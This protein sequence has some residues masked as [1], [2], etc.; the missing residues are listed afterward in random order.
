MNF[1]GLNKWM[2]RYNNTHHTKNQPHKK[3]PNC[4]RDRAPG[5]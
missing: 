1:G 5:L 4:C 3:I 2:R